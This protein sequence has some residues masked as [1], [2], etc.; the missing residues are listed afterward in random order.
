[1]ATACDAF[2]DAQ[3]RFRSAAAAAMAGDLSA[4]NALHEAA[5]VYLATAAHEFRCSDPRRVRRTQHLR[6]VH[7]RG[8]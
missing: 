2:S 7:D 5:R 4:I 3:L 1:M 8:A 6:L